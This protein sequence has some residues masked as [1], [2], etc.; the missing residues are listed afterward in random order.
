[1]SNP[2]SVLTDSQNLPFN[3][4]TSD[5][6]QIL[7]DGPPSQSSRNPVGSRDGNSIPVG[8]PDGDDTL[9]GRRPRRTSESSTLTGISPISSRDGLNQEDMNVSRLPLDDTALKRYKFGPVPSRDNNQMTDT[10]YLPSTTGS[11]INDHV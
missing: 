7:L 3:S 5:T 8:S 10:V 1:M 2:P 6:Q 4:A 9:V 11:K